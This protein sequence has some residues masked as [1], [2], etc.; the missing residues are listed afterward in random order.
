MTNPVQAL[1]NGERQRLIAHIVRRLSGGVPA[2]QGPGGNGLCVRV[3]RLLDALQAATGE[4]PSALC[5]HID[6]VAAERMHDG[7]LLEEIQQA[8]RVLEEAAWRLAPDRLPLQDQVAV[9]GH[10]GLAVGRARDYLA[11]LYQTRSNRAELRAA[12]LERRLE[13]LSRARV[14]P[15]G[16]H[17][18]G[19]R[20]PS[21]YFGHH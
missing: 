9:L 5:E 20:M 1:F 14:S 10:L 12:R 13:T 15:H 17:D 18:E 3:E 16:V 21:S 8:L 6:A 4:N 7:N 19:G 2:Y 11:R